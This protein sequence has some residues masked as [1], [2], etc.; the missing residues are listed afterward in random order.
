MQGCGISHL[1]T[2]INH[3]NNKKQKE[4]FI[5]QQTR[6]VERYNNF[7]YN[8]GNTEFF[9][10]EESIINVLLQTP[11]LISCYHIAYGLF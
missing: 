8:V 11:Y 7:K 1:S 2:T 9:Q 3:N 10:K 5:Q 4:K 6:I